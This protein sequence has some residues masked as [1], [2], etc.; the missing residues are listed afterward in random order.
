MGPEC[1]KLRAMPR[2]DELTVLLR[3]ARELAKL[4]QQGADLVAEA[5][6]HHADSA[7]MAAARMMASDL[8]RGKHAIEDELVAFVLDCSRC[9]PQVDW[10]P[11]EGCELGHWAHAEPAPKDHRPVLR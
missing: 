10:V 4:C 3:S 8:Q 5:R 7:V 2:R 1:E 6:G 9:G 11:G